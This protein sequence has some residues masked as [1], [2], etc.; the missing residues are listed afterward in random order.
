[1]TMTLESLRGRVGDLDSHEM[2]PREHWEEHFGL[3]GKKMVDKNEAFWKFFRRRLR[4]LPRHE[5]GG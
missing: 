2:M 1:M 5:H 3:T 4:A